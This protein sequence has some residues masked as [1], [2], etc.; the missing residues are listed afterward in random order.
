[1]TRRAK[2]I[3][4]ASLVS[5]FLASSGKPASA[6]SIYTFQALDVPGAI[7]TEAFGINDAGQIAGS[8]SNTD[9]RGH[10]FL[11]TPMAAQVLEPS[12]L[13]LLGVGLLGLFACCWLRHGKRASQFEIRSTKRTEWQT[14][15]LSSRHDV[16]F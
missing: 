7:L 16:H 14:I 2:S 6:V 15:C 10:G 5:G 3:V 12:T 8:Y 9:Q 11:A 13:S 4:M 1:M